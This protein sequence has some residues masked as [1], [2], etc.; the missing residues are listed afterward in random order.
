MYNMINYTFVKL[1]IL[2]IAV[3]SFYNVVSNIINGGED[4]LDIYN[5][6]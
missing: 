1:S 6:G 2:E 5:G 3:V 4:I